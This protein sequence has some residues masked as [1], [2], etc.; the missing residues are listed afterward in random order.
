MLDGITAEKEFL[1]DPYGRGYT[2][3]YPLP[4]LRSSKGLW[5]AAFDNNHN[6]Q[7]RGGL[8][9]TEWP[10]RVNGRYGTMGGG[11]G[12]NA[13]PVGIGAQASGGATEG[14]RIVNEM[15]RDRGVPGK[16][17][18]INCMDAAWNV[19]G[20][21]AAV[22]YVTFDFA[23]SFT[24]NAGPASCDIAFAAIQQS[25]GT[26]I[27]LNFSKPVELSAANISLNTAGAGSATIGAITQVSP[28]SSA[29]KS[30]WYVFAPVT[31]TGTVDVQVT[32]P[33]VRPPSWGRVIT[34]ERL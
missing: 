15:I 7:I 3:S 4:L 34:V 31:A 19:V 18:R 13:G 9:H 5:L 27:K 32:K 12:E 1:E 23:D 21:S 24:D 17:H 25:K 29:N 28:Q 22:G 16:G 10:G 11:I 2:K 6:C 33:G 26:V 20:V 30:E 8:G 14:A